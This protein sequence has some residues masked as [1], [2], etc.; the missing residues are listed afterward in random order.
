[1][2]FMASL[3]AN[4]SDFFLILCVASPNLIN[5]GVLLSLTNS[6]ISSIVLK[7]LICFACVISKLLVYKQHVSNKSPNTT[8]GSML[9]EGRLSSK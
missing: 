4:C 7:L 2:L 1:M 5:K 6:L 8:Y 9:D 3:L